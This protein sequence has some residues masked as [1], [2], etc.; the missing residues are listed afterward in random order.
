[1]SHSDCNAV[2]PEFLYH[3]QRYILLNYYNLILLHTHL[4]SSSCNQL[5]LQHP[6]QLSRPY[7]HP[8][9]RVRVLDIDEKELGERKV[10]SSVLGPR[11]KFPRADVGLV[12]TISDISWAAYRFSFQ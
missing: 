5:Q 1:M 11:L 7:Y 2:Q 12:S 6:C 10:R 9:D 3:G 8:S 4:T